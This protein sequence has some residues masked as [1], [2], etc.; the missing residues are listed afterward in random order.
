MTKYN[1]TLSILKTK[2]NSLEYT[3]VSKTMLDSHF[4]LRIRGTNSAFEGVYGAF[5]LRWDG[6]EGDGTFTAASE[7]PSCI[8]TACV[9]IL[10]SSLHLFLSPQIIAFSIQD[11]GSSHGKPCIELLCLQDLKLFIHCILYLNI[12]KVRDT[13]VPFRIETRSSPNCGSFFS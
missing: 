6:R 2:D 11:H 10:T 12:C 5:E 8:S 1:W 13:E 7:C 3:N 4:L 9:H